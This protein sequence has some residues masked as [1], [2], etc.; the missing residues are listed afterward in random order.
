MGLEFVDPHLRYAALVRAHE[1]RF[2]A[3]QVYGELNEDV[4]TRATALVYALQFDSAE[5]RVRLQVLIEKHPDYAPA[6]FFLAEEHSEDRV[7][8]LQTAQDRRVEHAALA[9]FLKAH[10]EGRVMPLFLDHSIAA[11]WIEKAHNRHARL[12]LSGESVSA[13][14]MFEP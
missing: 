13:L 11:D 5:R 1:G 8:S 4:P 3:R 10:E 7:G 9:E 2:I 12:A 6:Y 14:P